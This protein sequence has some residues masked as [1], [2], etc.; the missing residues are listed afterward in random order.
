MRMCEKKI[1][2]EKKMFAEIELMVQGR[3]SPAHHTEYFIQLG[4]GG[5]GRG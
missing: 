1:V 2:G 5:E 4:G 3:G